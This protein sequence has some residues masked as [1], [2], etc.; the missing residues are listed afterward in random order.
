[1]SGPNRRPSRTVE[2]IVPA[3]FDDPLRASGGD[4]YDRRLAA[5]LAGLGWRVR[6]HPVAGQW[7]W[8]DAIALDRLTRVLSEI[9]DDSLVLVDGLIGS[10]LPDVFVPAA[11]RL[12]LAVLVLMRL[13]DSP[14]GHEVD[15][16]SAR[17]QAVLEAA[18]AVVTVSAWTRDDLVERYALPPDRLRIALPGTEPAELAEP[19]ARGNRLLC[20]AAVTEHKGHD[21]LVDALERITDLDWD[22]TCV[23][24]LDREPGFVEQLRRRVDRDRFGDRFRLTGPRAGDELADSY[25]GA[26]L[27]VLPT[28]V[29]SY[30]MVLTEALARGIPVVASA[31]GGVPEAVGTGR[32]GR[33]PGLLV[34]P[35]DPVAL[36]DEL[37]RWLT[38]AQLRHD[39]RKAAL[40][41]R[42][43]LPSWESTA[44]CVDAVLRG[45][46]GGSGY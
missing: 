14:M 38:D 1:V 42:A 46:S 12:R 8:P 39:L 15:D 30:G 28:R 23:G 2:L 5:G 18:A 32:D 25:A 40:E 26:D 3:D 37:S 9:A 31:V 6:P 29:E 43:R 34:R 44:R 24:S 21:I 7:P 11:R 4:H 19:A 33:R 13:G 36:A 35:G 10:T 41:R 22:C 16:A 45:I 27:V 17:E 20:V